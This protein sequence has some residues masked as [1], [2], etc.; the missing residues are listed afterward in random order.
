MKASSI[1]SSCYSQL[2]NIQLHNQI[3]CIAIVNYNYKIYMASQIINFLCPWTSSVEP[4]KK[5]LLK[6]FFYGIFFYRKTIFSSDINL[7]YEHEN[8]CFK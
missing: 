7:N 3:Y 4:G 5:E 8:I 1:S 6:R 2:V